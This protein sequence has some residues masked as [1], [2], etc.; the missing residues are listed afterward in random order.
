MATTIKTVAV[1][2]AAGSL[3]SV[4]LGRLIASGKF[5]IKVLKR[6]GS[7]SSV[8]AGVDVAE[9]DFTSLD[10]LKSAFT[11]QDAV[12]SIVGD[13]G[14]ASQVLMIDA[15][16]AVGVKR[17]LPSEFGSNLQNPNARKLPVY[18]PKLKV[19]DHIIETSM[20]TNLTYTLVSNNA[21]LDWGL[22]HDFILST[23]NSKPMLVNGGDMPFSTTTLSSI[24]D[25]VVGIL[26]HPD[27]TKNR[28]VYIHDVVTTQNK[29]LELAKQ[30]APGKTWEPF[31]VSLDSMLAKSRERLANG[32]HDFETFVPLLWQAVLDP[33]F[34]GKFENTDNE[35]LGVKG[36]TD[37]DIIEIFK[38]HLNID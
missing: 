15:A 33:E 4:V 34:G 37:E 36:K 8:P 38:K 5:D 24:G 25:A 3:G 2:G 7:E 6:A 23:T 32:L 28:T 20:K 22:Q 17:F 27:E 26:S 21:F 13:K 30:A 16:A 10:S 9:V 18:Q 11:G 29:L 19:Q 1:V 31:T 12:V 14:T 35:L